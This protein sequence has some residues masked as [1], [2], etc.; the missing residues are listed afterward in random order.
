MKNH[1]FALIFWIL[2]CVTAVLLALYYYALLPAK[3]ASHFGPGGHPD[4]W[5]SKEE[6]ITFYFIIVSVITVL[7]TALP[8][9]VTLLPVSLINLPNKDYWFAP[10][11]SEETLKF[12]RNYPL[13][14][15]SATVLLVIDIFHQVFVVNI[16]KAASLDHPTLSIVLYMGFC[17]AWTVGLFLRFRKPKNSIA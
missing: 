3:V 12:L 5:T 9:L 1:R 2:T 13:W 17:L 16:G 7:F 11:R 8:Y 14:F 6:F 10:E 4:A 15:A